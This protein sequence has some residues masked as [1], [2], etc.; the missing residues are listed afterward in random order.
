MSFPVLLLLFIH[1]QRMACQ[2][3]PTCMTG[4]HA[5]SAELDYTLCDDWTSPS[6][7]TSSCPANALLV[8]IRCED[9]Q[10]LEVRRSTTRCS[11]S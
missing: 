2:R 7:S 6:T 5:R 10:C 3:L 1:V 8:G 11:A 9:P 4:Q